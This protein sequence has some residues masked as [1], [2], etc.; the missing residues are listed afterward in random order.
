MKELHPVDLVKGQPHEGVAPGGP[1]QGPMKE[2]HR[3]DLVKGQPHEGVAP[4]GPGQG[5]TP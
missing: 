1:G 4:S 5:A 3:V 2:L